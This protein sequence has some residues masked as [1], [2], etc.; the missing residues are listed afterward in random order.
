MSIETS[1][2]LGVLYIFSLEDGDDVGC[3]FGVL[4]YGLC[5]VGVRSSFEFAV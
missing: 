3:V 5:M 4:V 2:E 1:M